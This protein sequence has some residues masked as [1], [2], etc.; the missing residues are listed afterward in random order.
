[1]IENTFIYTY[2]YLINRENIAI[3]WQK[4]LDMSGMSFQRKRLTVRI[5]SANR[6]DLRLFFHVPPQYSKFIKF[7]SLQRKR[8][9]K[10]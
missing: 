8:S 4:I 10:S 9:T 2:V 7:Y 1:M 5:L 3:L 6:E